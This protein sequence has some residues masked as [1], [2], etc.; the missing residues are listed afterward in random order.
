MLMLTHRKTIGQPRPVVPFSSGLERK[1]ISYATAATAAG[2]A[3]SAGAPEASARIVYTPTNIGISAPIDLNGDGIPDFQ[4]GFDAGDHLSALV[5][6]PLVA[7]NGVVCYA[8]SKGCFDVV[9]G[10]VNQAVGPLKQ[11]ASNTVSSNSFSGGGVF[12]AAGGQYQ[13]TYFFGPWAYAKNRYVGVRFMIEGKIHY[14]WIRMSVGNFEKDQPITIS[15]Y[16]YE[17]IPN[18]RILE[19]DTTGLITEPPAGAETAE[20]PRATLGALAGGAAW[21]SIWRRENE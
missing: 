10:A 7:G 14:G 12:M 13:K 15:G 19:G 9:V 4:F 16:A 2:L 17:T 5:V 8:G 18:K 11:F 21:L 1:L 6:H 20:P 3:L